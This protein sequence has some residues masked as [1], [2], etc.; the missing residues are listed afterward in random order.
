MPVRGTWSRRRFLQTSLSAGALTFLA[1][2]SLRGARAAEASSDPGASPRDFAAAALDAS[3]RSGASYADVRIVRRRSE[4]IV[5]RES[6]IA[7]IDRSES[8]G[9]G[10]RCLVDGAW[11]F[12]A[13]RGA[14]R[15]DLDRAARAAVRMAKANR[16]A[17]S[18]PVVLAA[19]PKHLDAWQTPMTK[20]PFKV[21]LAR[22]TDLLLLAG[23][24]ALAVRGAR[25]VTS[26]VTSVAEEKIFSSTEGTFL[27][28]RI[29]RVWPRLEVAAL[30]PAKT[31][32]RTRAIDLPPAQ[33]GWEY[34]EEA[35]LPALA[36]LAAEEAV[37]SLSA[38]AVAP[39]R[40]DLVIDPTSLWLAIHETIG[41]PTELDRALGQE[42]GFA[43]A[44]FAR[45]EAL[46]SL[47]VGSS[48]LNFTADRTMPGGLATAG[49]DDDG[50]EARSWPI[51]RDGILVDYQKTR[52]QAS[53]ISH[54]SSGGCSGAES[55]SA[56]PIE[57][58][59]NVSLEPAEKPAG[60]DD[61][62][63]GVEN[64]LYL[65]GV[66]PWSVDPRQAS[67][68]FGPGSAR[69]IRKGK[70]GPLVRDVACRANTIDF[71]N[72]CDAIGGEETWEAGGTFL[73]LKGEP[74]QLHA[75][76]HGCPAARFR[77]IDVLNIGKRSDASVA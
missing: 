8:Y 72:A 19:E 62:I 53:W 74:P 12:C 34:V 69:V 1:A 33:A 16:A 67:F 3:G 59:A 29:T 27:D 64:G 22:K 39:G 18:R 5:A 52:E 11:G 55:W 60:I 49:Y 66:G 48:I 9:F 37:E 56:F 61:L 44:S 54:D 57:R 43:G 17:V 41:R 36:A 47:Q 51:V 28:Q 4:T 23:Q 30:D 77:G 58:M 20:D 40:T 24:A 71:W 32:F 46:S 42:D 65:T 70:L 63:A 45:P 14:A 6:R 31:R 10:V 68:Q 26:S 73:D 21:S 25:Y 75:A 13:G 7:A 35:G 76:S 2:S 38:R 50:V 15:A